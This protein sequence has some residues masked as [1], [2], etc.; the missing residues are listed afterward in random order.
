M[1]FIFILVVNQILAQGNSVSLL[2]SFSTDTYFI[3]AIGDVK[4]SKTFSFRLMYQNGFYGKSTKKEADV[5]Y[6]GKYDAY[7]FFKDDERYVH[8]NS[9]NYGQGVGLGVENKWFL[10]RK[11]IIYLGSTLKLHFIKDYYTLTYTKY[12]D[13]E[14]RRNL[15]LIVKHKSVSLGM[16]L[17][18]RYR[19]N[20][21]IYMDSKIALPF[22]YPIY[23]SYYK[24]LGSVYRTVG[25][26]PNLSIGLNYIIKK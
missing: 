5:P 21:Y 7:S 9:L 16:D 6:D 3:K 1:V 23:S 8:F 2:G 10:S 14:Y 25:L 12:K 15:D 13:K 4:V 18:F 26:E 22:Y 11:A 20:K 17:G 19:I 24:V